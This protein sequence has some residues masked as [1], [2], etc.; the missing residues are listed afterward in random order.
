MKRQNNN[1]L[2]KAGLKFGKGGAAQRYIAALSK[3][4]TFYENMVPLK[5]KQ[6]VLDDGVGLTIGDT[7]VAEKHLSNDENDF[8]K[9][10]NTMN[11]SPLKRKPGSV[12]TIAKVR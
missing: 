2:N 4:K 9:E 7:V 5:T 12:E 10:L 3:R 8:D 6:A 11:K 1:K